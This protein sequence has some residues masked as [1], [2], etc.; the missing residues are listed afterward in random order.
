L[1]NRVAPAYGQVGPDLFAPFARYLV[2]RVPLTSGMRV[3]DVATGRGAALF[4]AAERVGPE[5]FV[6]GI[7]LARQ[8][9]SELAADLERRHLTNAVVQQ[10]DAEALQFP[11]AS[12]DV[13]LCSF[14][15]PLFP[16][17]ERALA[18]MYR[19]LRPGGS[20]GICMPAGA[21]ERWLWYTQLV[22][23][24]HQ[25]HHLPLDWVPRV[26]SHSDVTRL[27]AGAGFDG[28]SAEPHD[29]EFVYANEQEW[30]QA[31][32]TDA[33]RQPLENMPPAVLDQFQTEVFARVVALKQ[34]D[35]LRF[36]RR[37][38]V[39]LAAKPSQA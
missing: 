16:G 38:F 14:A 3:L 8:M 29:V 13:V 25:T 17:P 27:L 15:L 19:V 36:I 21:D 28:V 1:Y 11:D 2:A 7:D 39:V 9:V 10:M 5:G 6:V 34:P 12:F 20:L 26:L 23:A 32:W 33:A 30:W 4:A 22:F 18:E 31:Q 35:G 24:Y 37:A